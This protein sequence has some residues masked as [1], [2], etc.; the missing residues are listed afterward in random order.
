MTRKTAKRLDAR[1][2]AE[3]DR[4]QQFVRDT[5]RW[6]QDASGER[7]LEH[8]TACLPV[9][10]V[11]PVGKRWTTW[12]YAQRAGGRFASAGSAMQRVE[13]LYAARLLDRHRSLSGK[14]R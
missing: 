12:V 2:A 8:A 3:V 6:V 10:G 14:A 5:T 1:T 13:N 7:Y 4:A 9:G 11:R